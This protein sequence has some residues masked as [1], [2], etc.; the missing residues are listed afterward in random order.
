MF[1]SFALFCL[2]AVFVFS[3]TFAQDDPDVVK[4][5]AT[6]EILSLFDES[7]QSLAQVEPNIRAGGLFR[8]LGFAVNFDD[9]APAQKI[10]DALLALASTIEPETLRNQLYEG[11]A[12][13]LCDMEKYSEAIG[14]LNRIV[15]PADRGRCQLEIAVKIVRAQ[16]RDKTL[17]PFDA[18]ELLRQAIGNAVASQN[19]FIEAVSHAFLGHELAR[20]G[21]QGEAATAFAVA[22]KIAAQVEEAD[23]RGRVLELVLFGQVKYDQVSS[24]MATLQ[25]VAD[26]AMKPILTHTLVSILID[27]EKYAE[28]EELLKTFPSGDMK[29]ELLGDFVMA[30]IKTITDAK[31]GELV[32]LVSSNELRERFLLVISGQLQKNNRND[33]A[34]QVSKRLQEPAVAE[35]SLF[36]G[37]VEALLEDNQFVEAV[38]FVEETEENEAIR[39]RLK[40]QI[41]MLQYQETRDESVAGQIETTFTS[42]EK[43]AV[44][45]LREE[46]KRTIEITDFTK[47]MDILFEIFQEQSRLD[48]AGARQTVKLIAEQLD[49]GTKP[50]QIISDRLLLARLQVELRDKEGAKANLGKLMQTL[51]AVKDLSELKDLISPLPGVEPTIEESAI[52]NQLFQIYLMAANLLARVDALVESQS[53]LA[54]AKELAKVESV[55]VVKAEKLLTLAQFL[56]EEQ[57]R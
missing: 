55:A 14:V 12:N 34:I 25:A 5:K 52:Q 53:A 41:L 39:Q 42:G 44:A 21:K 15:N 32:A 35:M 9:K 4:V 2:V 27:R 46:A 23:E 24:A 18:S 22:I 36:I 38:Q 3:A 28:A 54:K 50:I 16:E 11:V 26:P 47:R 20:H 17:E 29:D 33:V 10:A 49:K 31:V 19:H 48:F 43:I 1:R 6:L 13:A 45:D 8:L 40:R 51:S 7:L 57:S 37:K 56:A 30:N